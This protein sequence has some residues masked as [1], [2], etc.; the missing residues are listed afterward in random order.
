MLGG[1]NLRSGC[2]WGRRGT[3][4]ETSRDSGHIDRG[5]PVQLRITEDQVCP[6]LERGE[7]PLHGIPLVNTE[8]TFAMLAVQPLANM[9]RAEARADFLR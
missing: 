7:R 2:C 8:T 6:V 9:G 5:V 3:T 1:T 4:S